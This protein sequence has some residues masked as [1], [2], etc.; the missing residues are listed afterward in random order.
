MPRFELLLSLLL[1]APS[2]HPQIPPGCS[3]PT[4][5]LGT[6]ACSMDPGTWI[7]LSTNNFKGGKEMR[8]ALH[9]SVLE[10]T[11]KAGAWDPVHKTIVVLGS[12]HPGIGGA[13]PNGADVLAVYTDETNT[14]AN[15]YDSSLPDPC[16][17]YDYALQASAGG[18]IGHAYQHN[19]IDPA[20][21]LFYHREYGTGKVMFFDQVAN[22]WKQCSAFKADSYQVA[23]GLAFFP[24][25]DSLVF[26]DGDWGVF[27]LSLASGN[28]NGKW[29]QRAE[30]G[31]NIGFSPQLTGFSGYSQF[32]EYS[33]LCQCLM[34]GGGNGGGRFWKYDKNGNFTEMG[35]PPVALTVP[36]S[37]GGTTGS[38]ITV[39]PVSGYFLVWSGN[40]S[41]NGLAYRYNP[42]TD[43]WTKTGI[44]SPLFPGP[45]GG[46][47]ET[48]AVPISTYGVVMFV[49]LGSGEGAVGR[50]YLYKHT[51]R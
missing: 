9:G 32:D 7:Q 15:N 34:L 8:P 42:T 47:G 6:T 33:A 23:G 20:T 16:P 22:R 28:C 46:V 30:T 37:A 29:A 10:Y 19:T 12:S 1:L 38:I 35:A 31:V 5:R 26:V 49:Q 14:W 40:G 43:I 48:I 45:E 11:D 50:V 24:E 25:R 21:G 44:S 36:Q 17:D 41:D 4:T 18:G 39:D 3:K 27:E 13:C 51:S 2:A